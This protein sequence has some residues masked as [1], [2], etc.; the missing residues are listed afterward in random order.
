MFSAAIVNNLKIKDYFISHNKNTS[1]LRITGGT[2]FYDGASITLYGRNY[3]NIDDRGDFVIRAFW[4]DSENHYSLS[5]LIGY[6]DGRLFW[7][8]NDLAGA[9]I[10]SKNISYTG[11]IKFSCGLIIQ[12][13]KTSTYNMT[14]HTYSDDTS[15]QYIEREL[16]IPLT[17]T[18]YGSSNIFTNFCQNQMANISSQKITF[19]FL[20]S[21]TKARIHCSG[22][23]YSVPTTMFYDI[24]Y[25][26]VGY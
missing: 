22:L 13:G 10:V 1:F 20:T 16:E 24:A 6:P 2:D 3:S 21:N 18:T 5:D 26:I 12:W 4:K 17:L 25:L 8:G 15:K 23:N 14:N 9:A 19:G 11:Y 7:I